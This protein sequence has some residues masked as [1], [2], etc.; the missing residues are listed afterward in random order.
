[1]AKNKSSAQRIALIGAGKIGRLAAV[2]LGKKYD[3]TIYD[4]NEESAKECAG[5][6]GAY[7]QLDI[8]HAQDLRDA[9]EDKAMVISCCPYFCN[10]KIAT[11]ACDS[12][13]SYCD[14][15]EDIRS[16]MAIERIARGLSTRFIPQCGLAPGLTQIIANHM[17]QLYEP[18]T[19]ISIRVGALP[20]NP[21]NA[22]KYNLTWSTDGLINEYGNPCEVLINGKLQQVRP[23]EGYERLVIGDVEY[24]AFNTSGGLGTLARSLEGKVKELSY[25]TLRYL[26]HRD[27]MKFLM[28]DLQLNEYRGILKQIL[29]SAVP[30]TQQDRVVVLISVVGKA[31]GSLR[32]NTYSKVIPHGEVDGVHWTAIQIATASSLASVVDM[33]L[34]G[35]ISK[36]GFVRQEEIDFEAFIDNEYGSVF[37]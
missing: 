11:A 26:G 9:L 21:T 3:I 17:V 13:V 18:V 37:R 12:E 33:C 24:E 16:G 7:G 5:A 6:A 34:Q 32:E 35:K 2:L 28:V 25:K 19:S 27:L 30:T 15:S 23:L 29:E 20:E 1:M 36:T 14:L 22:L 4:I 8:N 10:E 31:D